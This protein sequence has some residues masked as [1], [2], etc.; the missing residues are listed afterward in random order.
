MSTPQQIEILDLRHFSARQLRP[1][2]TEQAALWQR[3]LRWDYRAATD[4]LLNY[5]DQ[6]ILPGFVATAR[7]KVTGYTFCVYEGTKAVIGDLFT[8]HTNPAPLAVNHTLI[9]HLLETLLHSPDIARIESQLLLFDAGIL[10]P[11]FPSFTPYPRLFLELD[12]PPNRPATPPTFPPSIELLRW[13]P[14][15]Y[16]SAGDLIHAAYQSHVDAQINDQY[17]TLAGSLRFLHNVIRFPGCGTFDPEASWALRS[18]ATGKLA[19]LLL[20][21][22]VAPDT[23]HITQLCVDPAYRGAHLGP[24]LLQLCLNHLPARRYNALT[25]TVTEANT[26]A[27]NLYR[28]A[29]FQLRHRF[30]ALVLDKP[31]HRHL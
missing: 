14:T 20:V 3:R 2:L 16:N 28:R 22:R 21:S 29:G 11:A 30:E 13:S 5:L 1:L 9:R 18:T 23:A 19:A 24:N 15:L 8:T 26:Q 17:R 10:P 7:G 31:P 6:R 12:L 27:V 25:L 4:I